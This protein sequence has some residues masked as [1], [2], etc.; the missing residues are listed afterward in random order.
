MSKSHTDFKHNPKKVLLRGCARFI[1]IWYNSRFRKEGLSDE[2]RFDT[3]GH[4]GDERRIG[5]PGSRA[6]RRTLRPVGRQAGRRAGPG[7]DAAR[8]RG[9]RPWR[10]LRRPARGGADG[11]GRPPLLALPGGR[12]DPARRK[13]RSADPRALP[14]QD[15][16]VQ[17]RRALDA[18][19]LHEARGG[20]E[21][22]PHPDGDFGRH[23][24]GG[25]AGLRRRGRHGD[26]RV[27]PGDGHV[28]DPAAPDDDAGGGE[29][30]RRRHPGELRRR[31]GRRQAHLR[32]REDQRRGRRARRHPVVRELDQ[33]RPP[34]APGRL[35]RPRRSKTRIPFPIPRSPFPV[36][37][38][39]FPVPP[40]PVPVPRSPFPVPRSPFP[41]PPSTSS[42]PPATSAT[43]SRPTTRSSSARR[44]G[45]S[46]SPRT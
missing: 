25:D 18:P 14:R 43:S 16:R 26:C 35:L 22:R 4:F 39:P 40:S 7:D 1:G 24:L 20:R 30:P 31:A 6:G 11:G 8:G 46:S 29:R 36:P 37:R 5:V 38:S 45:S 28:E 10:A 3:Q 41:V 23:G 21:A 13:G 42:S 17:G 2:I 9:A 32:R 34:R 12:P 27:L 15:G 19:G 44:S 33:H